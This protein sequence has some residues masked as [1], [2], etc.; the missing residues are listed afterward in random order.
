MTSKLNTYPKYLVAGIDNVVVLVH[1]SNNAY[2]MPA[3]V[4]H[5][6]KHSGTTTKVAKRLVPTL[7]CSVTLVSFDPTVV[8]SFDTPLANISS[9]VAARRA[10]FWRHSRDVSRVT[11]P[12]SYAGAHWNIYKATVIRLLRN[13]SA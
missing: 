10:I 6:K 12:A 4:D 7:P 3:S 9:P 1:L 8:S 13:R 5:K 2:V 11:S